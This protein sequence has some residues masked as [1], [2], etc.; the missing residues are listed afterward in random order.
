MYLIYHIC[1]PEIFFLLFWFLPFTLPFDFIRMSWVMSI[2]FQVKRSVCPFF[3]MLVESL[4]LAGEKASSVHI[5]ELSYECWKFLFNLEYWGTD[6][7]LCSYAFSR[8]ALLLGPPSS[9]KTT[10]LL[11]LAGKLDP[12]LKVNKALIKASILSLVILDT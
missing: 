10:L 6:F 7:L 8:M 2:F 12:N 3:K 5:L 11:A 4:S 1:C 9:G